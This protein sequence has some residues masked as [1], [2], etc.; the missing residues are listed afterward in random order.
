[1]TGTRMTGMPDHH[2]LRRTA[3]A[4][5][6]HLS[7]A[8]VLLLTVGCMT[9]P[10]RDGITSFRQGAATANQ[11]SQSTFADIN[12]FLRQQQIDRAS[13]LP[14]LNESEFFSPL[15]SEDVAKWN[16][17]FGL[18]DAY[19]ASLETLLDPAR[20][21]DT[22]TALAEL[23]E[24]IGTIEGGRL[25][26]GVAGGFAQLGGLLVQM[27]AEKEALAAIRKAD[28][29]IQSVFDTMMT[30]IGEDRDNGVRAMVATSWGDV[31][32]AIQVEFLTAGGT[33][34]KRDVATRYVGTLDQRDAQDASLASLRRSIGLLA[35]AHRE[36]A[37][38]D[39]PSARRM[40]DEVQAEYAAYRQRVDALRQQDG[41][42]QGSKP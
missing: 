23:G 32:G 42:S 14:T 4:F 24:K 30:A 36:L 19:A 40:L 10:D 27:R 21:S 7:L 6:R 28:P 39:P 25:P 8:A 35:A 16:R 12:T 13:Q 1:M 34:A 3:V 20:S 33:A 17:A 11:Q 2:P 41:Q 18:I 5:A 9:V 15:A 22:E 26:A 37:A 38:G 29:A 31:L